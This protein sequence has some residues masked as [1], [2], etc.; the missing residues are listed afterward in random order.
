M[1][2]KTSVRQY[3]LCVNNAAYPGVVPGTVGL[4]AVQV[5]GTPQS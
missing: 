1:A 5:V 2:K 4:P 3:L